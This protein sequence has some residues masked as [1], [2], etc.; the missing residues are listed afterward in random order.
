[1]RS[2]GHPQRANYIT[3]MMVAALGLSACGRI[4]FEDITADDDDVPAAPGREAGHDAAAVSD[5]RV[6]ENDAGTT[7]PDAG[8]PP[9]DAGPSLMDAMPP[10]L[11]AQ[12]DTGGLD[13]VSPID[14]DDAGDDPGSEP[15]TGI[16]AAVPCAQAVLDY[17]STLPSLPAA[18]V[19][20]GVLECGLQLQTI[21]PREW[22]SA[23]PIP[24]GFAA[25][26]AAAYRPDG[27][28][29]FVE[30]DERS[31]PI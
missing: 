31:T 22:T 3:C 16:D 20:D 12:S 10:P 5:A 7:R 27:V 9:P 21:T 26:V 13:A 24:T 19:L 14:D 15:D 28:Y 8:Q 11:D 17:C 30:V 1:M 18:P 6:A 25:R 2:P 29:V 23:S 4:G